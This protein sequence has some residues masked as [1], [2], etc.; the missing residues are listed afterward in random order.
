MLR[1]FFV[2]GEEDK[3]TF[4]TLVRICRKGEISLL[5]VRASLKI[6]IRHSHVGGNPVVE[7]DK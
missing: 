6:L 5:L 7:H 1:P 2:Q 3:S 4:T